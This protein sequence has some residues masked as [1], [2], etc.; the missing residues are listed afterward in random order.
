VPILRRQLAHRSPARRLLAVVERPARQA[1]GADN[2]AEL[3]ARSS[4]P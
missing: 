2:P 4:G 3:V 1:A